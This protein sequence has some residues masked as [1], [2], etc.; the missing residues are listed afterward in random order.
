MNQSN[1]LYVPTTHKPGYIL[2]LNLDCTKYLL[3]LAAHVDENP[4]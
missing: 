3:T 4:Q 1:Y 2:F